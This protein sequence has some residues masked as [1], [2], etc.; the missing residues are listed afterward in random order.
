MTSRINRARREL[1]LR[2]MSVF[3]STTMMAHIHNRIASSV[4]KQTR[5]Q[6]LKE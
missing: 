4:E 2:D 6:Q 5:I 3:G 1:H